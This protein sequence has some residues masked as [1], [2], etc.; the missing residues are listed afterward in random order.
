VADAVM[1]VFVKSHSLRAQ[2]KQIFELGGP[3]VMTFEQILRKLCEVLKI[4]R[5][6][7]P[8]PWSVAKIQAFFLSLLPTPLLTQDQLIS[9]RTDN[10]VSP[11]SYGFH[12]LEVTPTALDLILPNYLGHFVV[13]GRFADKKRSPS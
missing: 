4:K 5:V 1:A 8:L 9:L 2:S 7:L 12:D 11:Q 3:A 13:G 6:F 10:V